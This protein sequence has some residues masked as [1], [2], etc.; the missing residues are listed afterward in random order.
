MTTKLIVWT[1]GLE[2]GI[3]W[4][5][6][7][8]RSLIE[9]INALNDAI[10]AKRGRQQVEHMIGFLDG[11]VHNH[12]AIEDLYMEQFADPEREQHRA[13]HESFAENIEELKRYGQGTSSLSAES[14]CY[15]LYEW[16]IR[17]IKSIDYRLGLFLREHKER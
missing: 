9:N 1:T 13:E 12:F 14:L 8:H 2:T 6:Y 7:Q 3:L 15:D 16:F 5:D 10:R 4:Q 17:H 11:Y